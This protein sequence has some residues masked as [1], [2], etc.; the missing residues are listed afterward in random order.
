MESKTTIPES[1]EKTEK[2]ARSSQSGSS[3][4]SNLRSRWKPA[5]HSHSRLKKEDIPQE[6]PEGLHIPQKTLTG[7]VKKF[8]KEYPEVINDPEISSNEDS[9]CEEKP[10]GEKRQRFSPDAKRQRNQSKNEQE[11]AARKCNQFDRNSVANKESDD[12]K[13]PKRPCFFKFLKAVF[14]K[15]IGKKEEIGDKK[16]R[17][18]DKNRRYSYPARQQGNRPKKNYNQSNNRSRPQGNS[19]HKPDDRNTFPRKQQS[20]ESMN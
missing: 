6:K 3:P 12:K 9:S 16:N 10:S 18:N 11:N 19:K 1:S 4:K 15:I 7:E 13:Q 17:Q 14:L 8:Q 5:K 2:E 20:P